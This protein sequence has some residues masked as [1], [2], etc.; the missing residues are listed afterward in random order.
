MKKGIACLAAISTAAIGLTAPT[1]NAATGWTYGTK[2]DKFNAKV[3]SKLGKQIS[4][5][6]SSLGKLPKKAFGNWPGSYSDSISYSDLSDG[7]TP[8]YGLGGFIYV[9]GNE[10]SSQPTTIVNFELPS[11][12]SVAYD[13]EYLFILYPYDADDEG[14][15]HDICSLPTNVK[16]SGR[17]L[18]VTINCAYG[19][20]FGGYFAISSLVNQ[21]GLYENAVVYK[22]VSTKRTPGNMYKLRMPETNCVGSE[23]SIPG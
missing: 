21:V 18:S 23:C 14:S 12:Q 4:V 8:A 22:T 6:S 13:G 3:S 5:S 9:K 2:N 17:T 16:V 11:N 19:Q 15:T 20:G 10:S 1:A 7:T